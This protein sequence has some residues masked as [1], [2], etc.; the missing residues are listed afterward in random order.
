MSE[1]RIVERRCMDFWYW[2]LEGP[3]GVS[4]WQHRDKAKVDRKLSELLAGEADVGVD[5]D[6]VVDTL[7]LLSKSH[8]WEYLESWK[9]TGPEFWNDLIAAIEQSQ[10]EVIEHQLELLAKD[11]DILLLEKRVAELEGENKRLDWLTRWLAHDN[12]CDYLKGKNLR[13]SCWLTDSL[14]GK[15]SSWDDINTAIALSRKRLGLTRRNEHDNECRIA[16]G[17]YYDEFADMGKM[18]ETLSRKDGE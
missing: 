6:K 1:Y 13:C 14:T 16:I 4:I 3:D 15:V 2:S 17:L 5:V 12:G 11:T 7:R 8:D 9:V 18:A 10:K